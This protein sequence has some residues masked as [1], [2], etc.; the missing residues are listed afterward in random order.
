MFDFSGAPGSSEYVAYN[1]LSV[2]DGVLRELLWRNSV[3]YR[4]VEGSHPPVFV[5][6]ANPIL[7]RALQKSRAWVNPMQIADQRSKRGR[8]LNFQKSP[9]VSPTN[10]VP[11]FRSTLS[12]S[13]SFSSSRLLSLSSAEAKASWFSGPYKGCDSG[14]SRRKLRSPKKKR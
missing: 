10:T 3:S 11:F 14:R 2:Q 1:T 6:F 8:T 12:W 9:S 5:D 13:Y 4:N 7:I